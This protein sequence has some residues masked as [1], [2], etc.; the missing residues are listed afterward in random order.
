[1]N[2]QEADASLMTSLPACGPQCRL[3]LYHCRKDF[4]MQPECSVLTRQ[5]ENFRYPRDDSDAADI[6]PRSKFITSSQQLASSTPSLLPSQHQ[7][8]DPRSSLEQPRQKLVLHMVQSRKIPANRIVCAK[9][10]GAQRW[11]QTQDSGGG[12]GGRELQVCAA[13]Y[14]GEPEGGQEQHLSWNSEAIFDTQAL[15]Y[16]W[17]GRSWHSSLNERIH[18]YNPILNCD[19]V[20]SSLKY[21]ISF[22]IVDSFPLKIKPSHGFQPAIFKLEYFVLI[23]LPSLKRADL[24]SVWMARRI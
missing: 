6:Q 5:D 8:D 4:S 11:T 13:G 7:P 2:A 3:M 21:F 23:F 17:E 18:K 22:N 15:D 24:R 12:L 9:K 16:Q 20:L 10:C 14:E 19:Q 1:M